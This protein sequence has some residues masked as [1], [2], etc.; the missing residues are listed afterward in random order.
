MATHILRTDHLIRVARP[1]GDFADKDKGEDIEL[2]P[3]DGN[4]FLGFLVAMLFNVILIVLGA[5]GWELWRHIR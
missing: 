2:Q 5:V 3:E 4:I 1:T